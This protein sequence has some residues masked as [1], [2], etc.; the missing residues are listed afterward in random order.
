MQYSLHELFIIAVPSCTFTALTHLSTYTH[1]FSC[2]EGSMR[3]SA[4]TL[5]HRV[6]SFGYVIS[7]D[8]L[9]GK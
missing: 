4:S 2:Q 5:K 6:L 3:V 8:P 7:E 9:P 1:L